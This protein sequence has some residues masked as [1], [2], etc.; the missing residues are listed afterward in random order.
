MKWGHRLWD[1][2]NKKVIKSQDVVFNETALYKDE[3]VNIYSN[4]NN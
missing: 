1:N 3:F 4:E 2:K